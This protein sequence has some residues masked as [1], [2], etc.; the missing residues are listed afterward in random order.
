M[1]LKIKVVK[2]PTKTGDCGGV[3]YQVRWILDPG[4]TGYVIQ[5]VDFGHDVLKCDN[6][7]D[8]T[9]A[10]S[11]SGSDAPT[12]YEAWRVENGNVFI[13]TGKKP[14]NADTYRLLDH[15]QRKKK[16]QIV[17][18]VQFIA[19]YKLTLGNGAD[20][21]QEPGVRLAGSLPTR[22]TAPAGFD[23]AAARDHNLS[24][25]WDCCVAKPR[26]PMIDAGPTTSDK[27]IKEQVSKTIPIEVSPSAKRASRLIDSLPTWM[28]AGANQ[29][30]RNALITRLRRIDA[31]HSDVIRGG[32]ELYI[33]QRK[34]AKSY[35]VD[36]ES[37]LYLLNRYLF[38]LPRF[39]V[40]GQF[41]IFGGWDIPIRAE[42]FDPSWPFAVRPS[43]L[44]LEGTFAGYYGD[45]YLALDEFDYF[46]QN[47]RRRKP[48]ATTKN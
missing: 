40:V 13:G 17:G 47:Y 12:Y 1:A 19:G 26:E 32:I 33:D 43:G 3:E 9:G 35:S 38:R 16:H 36:E 15:T 44:V 11:C 21:W 42:R 34:R 10:K 27:V 30:A 7:A 25:E 6:T 28:D 5:R 48:P 31:F 18:K 24:V 22:A 41:R 39:V 4:D 46:K 14:H 29:Q 37:K 23:P 20:D 45:E 2:K 8:I